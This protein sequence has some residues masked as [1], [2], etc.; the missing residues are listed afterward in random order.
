MNDAPTPSSPA[1][2]S[3]AHGGEN[4]SDITEAAQDAPTVAGPEPD[5]DVSQRLQ[6]ARKAGLIKK[7]QFTTHLLKNLDALVYAELSAL[8]Y[9]ECVAPAPYI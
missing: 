3:P 6:Q 7:L 1:R 2:P 5:S 8:Y 4:T 9:M